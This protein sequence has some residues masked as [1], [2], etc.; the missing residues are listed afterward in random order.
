MYQAA[1]LHA[2]VTPSSHPVKPLQF[3][4]NLPY[5]NQSSTWQ[6]I[7]PALQL[8]AGNKQIFGVRVRIERAG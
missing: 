6:S 7:A 1:V 2:H 3:S 5:D 4:I 8:T